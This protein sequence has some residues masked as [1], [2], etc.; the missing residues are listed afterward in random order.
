MDENGDL[1]PAEPV[2][3]GR[4]RPWKIGELERR[5]HGQPEESVTAG[6]GEPDELANGEWIIKGLAVGGKR[7]K[8]GFTFKSGRIETVTVYD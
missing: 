1:T 5:Y 7:M 3:P 6:F 4:L 2:P 8:V